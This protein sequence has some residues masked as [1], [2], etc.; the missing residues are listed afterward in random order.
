MQVI[1]G[2]V[3]TLNFLCH[4]LAILAEG[5]LLYS[6]LFILLTAVNKLLHV[7]ANLVHFINGTSSPS[8]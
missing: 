1:F 5:F 6:I 4:S 2:H 7:V 3:V 8:L